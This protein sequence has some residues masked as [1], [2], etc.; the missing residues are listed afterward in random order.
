M[1]V[2]ALSAVRAA[3]LGGNH[4]HQIFA[5]KP[6]SSAK[7]TSAAAMATAALKKLQDRLP[8]RI[9]LINLRILAIDEF[10]QACVP[11]TPPVRNIACRATTC[12]TPYT[13]PISSSS[14]FNVH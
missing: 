13:T 6:P 3:K 7:W 1:M 4:I 5:L 2:T 14:L 8:L 11:V 10:C 12:T 9:F